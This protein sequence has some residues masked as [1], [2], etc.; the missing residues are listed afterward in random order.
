MTYSISR[1]I[2]SLINKLL[3]YLYDKLFLYV[4]IQRNNSS[5]SFK[6]LE[7]IIICFFT[8]KNSFFHIYEFFY[9]NKYDSIKKVR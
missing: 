1:K 3:I 2:V 6:I 9:D 7:K 8:S 4:L 5:N